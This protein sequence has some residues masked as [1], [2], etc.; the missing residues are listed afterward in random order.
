M[1]DRIVKGL[2]A[3]FDRHRIVFW[4]DAAREL[5]STFDAL[6]MEGVEKIVLANNEFGVKHR[7]LREAPHQRFL[8]YREGPEPD[9]ID[10][11]LLDIQMS[12]GAF[13]ADQAALWLTELGLGLEMEGVVRGHEEF[14]RSGKR[15]EQ[16][17]KMVAG[18]DRLEAIKVKM[19]VVCVKGGEGAG[20]DDIVERLLAELADENDDAIKLI[21]RARLTDFLWQQ[22]ARHFNYQPAN[23]SVGDLAITLFKSA[24][25]AGL[26]G[27]PH[28]SAEA[29]VFFK[30]WKNNRLNVT[31]F[32]KLSAA[33]AEVL[34]IRDDLSARDFRHLMDLD[35]FEDVD[36]AIISAL[37]RG[38]AAKTLAHAEVA[39]WIRQR[40]QNHW[41]E[42][43]KDLYEAVGYA[44]EFQFALS[45]VNLGMLSLAEGVSRY[46]S[47]WFKIDQLYRKFIRHMQRSAQ[48]S[49]MSEL[50]EQVENHYVN[51]YL[52][53]LNDAWQ[54]HIDAAEAWDAPGIVRQRDFYQTHV[55]EFR[56]KG[57]KI[58]VIISDA[59][60]YEVAEELLGRVRA[61]DKYDADLDPMLGSLPTYTQLGMA[62][63]LPNRDLQIA[64]NE[65]SAAFVDGQSSQ[66][67]ENR[68]KILARGRD[69]DRTTALMADELLAMPKD[70]CRTLFRDHDVIY[71]YHN[72]I[73]VIGDKPA[74]EEHVFDAAEDT[75]DAMVQLVRKLTSAN[76]TS[77]LI[78]ADHG[79]IYQH[80]PIEESDFS[81]AEVAGDAILFRNRRFVLGHGLKPQQGLR[82]FSAAAAGLQGNVEALIP[83][84][85]NRL[86]LKGSGSRFVHGGATLQEAVVP[87]LKIT[88]SRQ[89]DTSQVEVEITASSS[90]VITSGQI[91]VRFYQLDAASEKT[92][93][94][95]LR[96]GI[97]SGGGELISD[98]H[99]LVF[100]FRSENP[101]EREHQVRFLMSRKADEFNGQEVILK[102]EEQHGD[103]SH[104]R[105]YRTARYMLR[106]SFTNDFDF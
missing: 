83:K 96:A 80:R 48:A 91:S 6:Q 25:A 29:L 73:D 71:V 21:E 79:F 30:R 62:S 31:V 67:I 9:R 97:Y 24:H 82:H 32:E 36:R 78:T 105:E 27:T 8:I 87:V 106:R 7:V 51:S 63:L 52:L 43:Y 23:P 86:R 28:L 70:D 60:R 16:L 104:F 92:R 39:G 14:F 76:A 66:G 15:L 101:R 88:K 85:I 35:T 58:C 64:D 18:D 90:Q 98:S 38:V 33:Y 68:K 94:R 59:M 5:R 13:K 10:N 47:T 40:R 37:V 26:G 42:R 100:D 77:L 72:R 44:S 45:Q 3:A 55:G 69:G 99:N 89:S 84:S 22:F 12:Q 41:Y 50:F 49:L 57:Q 4:T 34:P 54:A 19:L 61:L 53:K 11:W 103:T 65:T 74:T 75:L 56:R 17:R 81:G 2:E 93:A 20:F 1:N 46:A 102:L 95:H